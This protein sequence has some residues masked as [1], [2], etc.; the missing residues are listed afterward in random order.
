MPPVRSL[1]S[2]KLDHLLGGG[3]PDN[4]A[5]LVVG[6]PGTGKTTLGVQFLLEGVANKENGLHILLEEHPFSLAQ[7]FDFLHWCGEGITYH[8]AV[9]AGYISVL[10]LLSARIG[11]HEKYD[12]PNVICPQIYRLGD[13]LGVIFELVR[14]QNIK[15]IVLDSLQSF[16]LVAEREV[17]QIRELLLAI[18]EPYRRV[19]IG[20][21]VISERTNPEQAASYQFMNH[22]FD[23]IISLNKGLPEDPSGRSLQIEKALWA[24]HDSNTHQFQISPKLGIELIARP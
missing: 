14:D 1:G 24:P 3:I 21:L 16:L 17:V 4:R 19:G 15:R 8:E 23:G 9:Q 5:V 2:E 20:L 13:L 11:Y 12:I 7:R 18:I 10:D 6:G 22:V